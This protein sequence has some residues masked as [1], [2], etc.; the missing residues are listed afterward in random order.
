MTYT[1]AANSLLSLTS[2][3]SSPS[4]L[5]TEST[6]VV[7]EI[8]S[9]L[10]PGISTVVREGQRS[11]PFNSGFLVASAAHSDYNG[12]FEH[13]I[14]FIFSSDGISW[15]VVNALPNVTATNNYFHLSVNNR[16]IFVEKLTTNLQRCLH[17]LRTR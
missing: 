9:N 4:M 2:S 6:T 12:A 11:V 15:N 3:A 13:D 14:L 1:G 17:C 16:Y 10:V 8:Y 7:G 5:F